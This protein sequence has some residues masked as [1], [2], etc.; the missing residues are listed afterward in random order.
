MKDRTYKLE[1]E[2]EVHPSKSIED[3]VKQVQEFCAFKQALLSL[4]VPL[5]QTRNSKMSSRMSD[6]DVVNLC[7]YFGI[8][9][10]EVELRREQDGTFK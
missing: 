3:C 1:F 6:Q 8:G 4:E 5:Q 2:S 7:T 10:E 9:V